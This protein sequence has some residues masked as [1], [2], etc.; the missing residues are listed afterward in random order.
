MDEYKADQLDKGAWQQFNDFNYKYK[1]PGHPYV[2]MNAK[3]INPDATFAMLKTKPQIL[4]IIIAEKVG[5]SGDTKTENLLEVVMA[6]LKSFATTCNFLEKSE[7]SVNGIEG[8]RV[9]ADVVLNNQQI[10]Y[11]IWVAAKNG[12]YYQLHIFGNKNDTEYIKEQANL[13]FANFEIIDEE[14]VYYSNRTGPFGSFTSETFDYTLD[15]NGTSWNKWK[16]FESY[17]P[18]AEIGT[19][20][21]ND[22]CA[23][24]IP[25]HYATETPS[26][27]GVSQALLACM[28]IEYPNNK[29]EELHSINEADMHGYTFD[30]EKESNGTW[31]DFRLK[32][33]SGSDRGFLIAALAPKGT[34]EKDKLF[35]EI[36]NNIHFNTKDSH[37]FDL[38]QLTPSQRKKEAEIINWIGLFYF[39]AKQYSTSVKFFKLAMEM[40]PKRVVYLTN[41][42]DAYDMLQQHKE[43]LAY[44]SN[45]GEIHK[46][47]QEVLSYKAWSLSNSGRSKEALE[48][49]EGL[50]DGNYRN[51]DA[52]I[53]FV[54]LLAEQ[55][56]WETINRVFDKYSKSGE[57]ITLT[58]IRA[59]LFNK[60]GNYKVAIQTLEELQKTIPFNAQIAYA[61]IQNYNDIEQYHRIL[62]ISK[63]LIDKGFASA[64]SYYNKGEAEYNL[65]WYRQSKQSFEEALK[66]APK[67][68]SIQEY[69]AHISSLLGEGNNSSIKEPITPVKMPAII[70]E[71]LASQQDVFK[72]DGYDSYY[73][74][75]VKGF[76]FNKEKNE[77]KCTTYRKIKVLD[78]GAVSTFSTFEIDF[79]PN[80]EKVYV[81]ELT[82][83]NE[84]GEIV[85]RGNLSDYFIVDKKSGIMDTEDQTLNIP[86]SHLLPGHTVGLTTTVKR[87]KSSEKFPF[88]QTIMSSQ[89]PILISAVF[90]EGHSEAIQYEMLN[91]PMPKESKNG[92]TWIIENPPIYNWEP[93]QPEHKTFLPTISINATRQNWQTL[94]KE[95]LKKIEDKLVLE[96][97]TCDLAK[98]LVGEGKNNRETID[99]LSAYVQ[100]EYTYKAIEFGIRAQIPNTAGVTVH[101]KY[102]DCKDHTVLLHQLLKAVSIKSH[103]ALV[104]TDSDVEMTLPSLDQ[105]NHMILYIPDGEYGRFVDTTDKGTDLRLLTPSNL[106]SRQA[107]ILDG[108]RPSFTKI[109]SYRDVDSG[110]YSSR[111]IE[112][113]NSIDLKIIERVKFTGYAAG[114]MRTYLKSIAKSD[115]FAWS[116]NFISNYYRTAKMEDFQVLN[117]YDNSK[118]L[119][120]VLKYEIARFC[121]KSGDRLNL[122]IPGLWEHYYLD[123]QPIKDRRTPFKIPYP[124][125]FESKVTVKTPDKKEFLKVD[126]HKKKDQSIFGQWQMFVKQ[127][128]E[129]FELNFRC[130]LKPGVYEPNQYPSYQSMM[131]KAVTSITEKEYFMVIQ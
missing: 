116:Q 22:I 23:V 115:R 1:F 95:Y 67:D 45:Y 70:A 123:V 88:Q 25:V 75:Y 127:N 9:N 12:F 87:I 49:Y 6:N 85:S 93:S 101:H 119:I 64:D 107:F 129:L 56:E 2:I 76:S 97:A 108:E 27:D 10:S 43:A 24:V 99:L 96:K 106:G 15:L 84:E 65:E 86:V 66:F 77:F 37:P 104:N 73:L 57:T 5:L 111:T 11:V 29:I 105:F 36:F 46:D 118:E 33:L 4:F 41:V 125:N 60:Q 113:V 69:I 98:R 79:N 38:Q 7:Y 17:F 19:F 124:L 26:L 50:F 91:T 51:D 90:Y 63:T 48:I 13:L 54:Y 94:G 16:D 82:V 71:K 61:L 31:Y 80:Y 74:N 122:K 103:L 112:I 30:Y 42:L 55:K 34:P 35:E 78:A 117:L 109:P 14:Q 21:N 110:L 72:V 8:I 121:R 44:L 59:D 47:N 100:T 131:E 39:Q 20:I 3:K 120:L 62:E 128:P 32:V 52:F 83:W 53:T 89:H 58:L 92:L 68:S 114:F 130:Q 102:G 81:N 126:E 40:Y 28:D 18:A